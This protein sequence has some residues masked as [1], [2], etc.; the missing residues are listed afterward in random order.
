MDNSLVHNKI[1]I[2]EGHTEHSS[3]DYEDSDIPLAPRLIEAVEDGGVSTSVENV[4]QSNSKIFDT[5]KQAV[6]LAECLDIKKSTPDDDL[7]DWQMAPYIEAVGAQNFSYFMAQEVRG[8]LTPAT[9]RMH[10]A[11]CVDFPTIPALLKEYAELM[12]SCGI[13]GDALRIFEELELWDNLIYCYRLLG[14]NPAA[15]DL[16]KER[17][18]HNPE[19]PRLWCSL[20]DVTLNDDNYIKALEVSGNRFARAERS[21]ARSAYNRGEYKLS[22]S[23]WEASLALNSLHPDGWFALGSAALKARDFDK[24]IDGFT[25]AVQLDPDNGE[26]WNNIACLHMM[27]KRNKE[28]FTAFKE[29]LKNEHNKFPGKCGAS[30]P[31]EEKICIQR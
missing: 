28:A 20:G 22:R 6:I 27:K 4:S 1:K 3:N 30:I 18:Q 5:I 7:Q 24:A 29:A 26:A 12:V 21:L 10:Y 23:H 19:D 13:V 9:D 17:L 25:R 31:V 14:K 2:L 8:Y 11:Y 15:I 16:I